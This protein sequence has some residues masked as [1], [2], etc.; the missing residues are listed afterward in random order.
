[1]GRRVVCLLVCQGWPCQRVASRGPAPSRTTATFA[2]VRW[3]PW[4]TGRA[5][6]RVSPPPAPPHLPN[7]HSPISLCHFSFRFFPHFWPFLIRGSCTLLLPCSVLA[8]ERGIK[9]T[10]SS[11]PRGEILM[12][13][14]TGCVVSSPPGLNITMSKTPPG[15]LFTPFKCFFGN[16]IRLGPG[17]SPISRKMFGERMSQLGVIYGARLESQF[18][19]C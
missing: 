12:A 17:Q 15:R 2:P 11:T 13:A 16:F 6:C 5:I 1:M 3:T 10:C 9:P 8:Q 4:R 19:Q 14:L 18:S 7:S